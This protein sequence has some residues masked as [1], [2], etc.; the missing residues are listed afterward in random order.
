MAMMLGTLLIFSGE[1]YETAN[2]CLLAPYQS[3][4]SRAEADGKQGVTVLFYNIIPRRPSML[5][6]AGDYSPLER[7]ETPILPYL[8]SIHPAGRLDIDIVTLRSTLEKQLGPEMT[9]DGNVTYQVLAE[10]GE[11][12]G[13]WVL[14]R[15]RS[16]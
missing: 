11:K 2:R 14:L 13:G 5:Y 9:A 16:L 7:E 15:V 12:R 3:L 6:Y 4:A 10:T 1:G 8:R